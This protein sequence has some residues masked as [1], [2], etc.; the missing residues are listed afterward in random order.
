M[1]LSL[2]PE[3][4]QKVVKTWHNLLGRHSTTLLELTRVIGLL[5]STLQAV[6]HPKIQLR[7]LQQQQIVCRR[8][9]MN[10]QSVVTLNTK[11]RTE[12]TWWIGNLRFCNGR[13]FS[14]LNPQ[15]IIQTDPSL[16]GWEQSA[17][18]FKHQGN[19]QRKRELST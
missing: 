16:T 5:S 4:V 10:Y 11:S 2:T 1:T 15:I 3:K 14:Q 7:F 9:E 13:T 17:T 6:E 18:G 12:L 19:G 8:E